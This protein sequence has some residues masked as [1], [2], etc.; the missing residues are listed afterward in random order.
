MTRP[1]PRDSITIPSLLLGKT[2]QMRQMRLL[3]GL[4][5]CTCHRYVVALPQYRIKAPLPF[6]PCFPPHPSFTSP[7]TQES[8][9]TYVS[10]PIA[11]WRPSLSLSRRRC[12][13]GGDR[14]PL[15]AARTLGL[16][17]TALTPVRAKDGTPLI[18]VQGALPV[19]PAAGT[20]PTSSSLWI[21]NGALPRARRGT[22]PRRSS[23][24]FLPRAVPLLVAR[25]CLSAPGVD[26]NTTDRRRHRTTAG[27]IVAKPFYVHHALSETG[28]WHRNDC[29]TPTSTSL[30]ATIFN[31]A[32][33]NVVQCLTIHDLATK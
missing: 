5:L 29:P 3:I 19:A 21:P 33:P 8:S 16:L 4:G 9:T 7:H 13:L 6:A 27:P 1:R 18:T 22:A 25:R 10:C 32:H 17:G 20:A 12:G 23:M 24:T 15:R 30:L 2:L 14:R 31:A 28:S 26:V 11:L